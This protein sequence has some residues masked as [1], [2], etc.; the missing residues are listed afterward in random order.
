MRY[1]LGWE[2]FK[3]G[4]LGGF[5]VEVICML[6]RMLLDG[7]GRRKGFVGSLGFVLLFMVVNFEF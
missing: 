7:V 1:S 5:S 6:G 4:Y 3:E 2:G